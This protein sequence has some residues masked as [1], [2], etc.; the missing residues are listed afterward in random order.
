M[1]RGL[2]WLPLLVVFGWLA[3]AG[4]NEYQKVESYRIWAQQFQRA[5]YDI[6][7]VLGQNGSQL[8]W[9]KPTRRGPIH[10]QSFSLHQVQSIQL[11]V[12]DQPVDLE[13]PPQNSRK[14]ALQFNLP[15]SKILVPF[16]EL[17]LAV[18]WGRF[19]RR[20][21]SQLQNP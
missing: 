5:K 12:E 2:L 15:E 18:E 7:A 3:W 13:Q 10:L 8:T 6:Y 16:T 4:W 17:G 1:E 21:L 11:L 20:E 14:V 19:L 9:G